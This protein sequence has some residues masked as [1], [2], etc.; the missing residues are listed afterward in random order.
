MSPF[1]ISYK[2]VY[3]KKPLFIFRSLQ[4]KK[5]NKK[6]K[7]THQTNMARSINWVS[8][9]CQ[10]NL[11]RHIW[12]RRLYIVIPF[13][14]LFCLIYFEK[15][16]VHYISCSLSFYY[17]L[18]LWS[19]YY[20]PSTMLIIFLTRSGLQK[21]SYNWCCIRYRKIIYQYVFFFFFGYKIKFYSNLI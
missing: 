21:I 6:Q 19:F 1:G 7:S 2:K 9:H 10:F 15:Y 17:F 16:N 3:G 4:K 11:Y 18:V 5:K 8:C 13:H 12:A 20:Q 14:H